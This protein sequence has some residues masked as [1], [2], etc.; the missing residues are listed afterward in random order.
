MRGLGRMIV[1]GASAVATLACQGCVQIGANYA[2]PAPSVHIY[3]VQAGLPTNEASARP[4]VTYS[5]VFQKSEIIPRLAFEA[6]D[7]Y[8]GPLDLARPN[9]AFGTTRLYASSTLLELAAEREQESLSPVPRE[10]RNLTAEISLSASSAQTGLGFDV[11]VAPR[12]TFS[13]EG[14]LATR[15][16]GGE[17][18]IGQNFDKRG[19]GDPGNSW[20]LFAG[21]DGEA[22]VWEPN[23]PGNMSINDMALRDKVTVGDIQAGVSFKQGP[24][25][26]SF[27]Y[28][29]REVEYRERNI[30]ASENEDFAGVSF[31]I[32]R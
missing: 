19:D 1:F 15:R 5:G 26:I 6:P 18:R 29:R 14:A 24:G 31:T 25:Q 3:E 10:T 9:D 17:V 30:G 12:V 2:T 7:A 27:S 22:L 32:R 21:A 16:V 23:A 11:G 28:I 4:S 8:S 13:R 20:Y